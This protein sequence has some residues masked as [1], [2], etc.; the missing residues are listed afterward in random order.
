MCSSKGRRGYRRSAESATGAPDGNAVRI[1]VD[2][3]GG[4][5][6]LRATVG[7]AAKVSVEPGG[8]EVVLVGD[9]ERLGRMLDEIP[10]DPARLTLAN[11]RQTIRMDAVGADVLAGMTDSSI[12]VALALH[13]A[14]DV[15]AVVTAGHT[16]AAILAASASLKRLPRIR[17]AALASV[18]PTERGHGPR[19]DPFALILDVGATLHAT[20]DDLVGFAA[21]GSAYSSVVSEIQA[22]RVALLS[23]GVEP[24]RGTP[25]IVEAYKRL[26]ASSGH[27]AGNVEGLDIPRGTVDV[28]VCDGFLGNVVLKMLEG[29]GDVLRD[30]TR[31]AAQK[32]V[33]N[34]V[35]LSLLSGELRKLGELTDWKAYGGAPVL[36]LNGLVIKAHGRSEA[37]AIRN[38][39]R[40]AAKSVRGNLTAR[41][42][43]GLEG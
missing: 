41:I 40:L 28:I 11:A 15:E 25:S 35:A 26:A 39:I 8:I 12:Q 32:R 10:H 3:M 24:T 38:A 20:A 7:G 18:Y 27:F 6:G 43:A 4:D 19:N 29:I 31:Q 1:A 14:G 22:P 21:M 13:A 5:N 37:P 30:M 23:N 42:R 2:A 34:R 16:G 33:R 36:G 9:V 17:R